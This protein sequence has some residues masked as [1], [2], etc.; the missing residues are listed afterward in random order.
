MNKREVERIRKMTEK[1]TKIQTYWLHL[2]NGSD[3]SVCE[4]YELSN[5]ESIVSRFEKAAPSEMFVVGDALSGYCY[6]PRS[7]IIYISTGDV[8]V[9]E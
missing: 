6:I 1:G 9:I 7:S 5:S 2:I 4:E 8:R 3:V